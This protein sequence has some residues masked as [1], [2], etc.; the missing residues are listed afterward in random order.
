MSGFGTRH[1]EGAQVRGIEPGVGSTRRDKELIPANKSLWKLVI[2][3]A[4]ARFH[5]WPSPAASHW[6]HQK[7]KQLGG[8]FISPEDE[9]RRKKIE[10]S[11]GKID[12]DKTEDHGRDEKDKKHHH[13][14]PHHA[15]KDE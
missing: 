12:K 9:E 14:R 15:K 5:K 11:H 8:R 10:A 1:Q 2:I 4:H 7:Y 13:R 6:A 3:Q